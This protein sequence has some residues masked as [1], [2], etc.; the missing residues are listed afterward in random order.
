MG[1]ECVLETVDI[2]TNLAYTNTNDGVYGGGDTGDDGREME[3]GIA[4]R[5]QEGISAL[6]QSSRNSVTGEGDSDEDVDKINGDNS[7]PA[8]SDSQEYYK[9]QYGH[10]E[11]KKGKSGSTSKAKRAGE[12]AEGAEIHRFE[13]THGS[14]FTVKSSKFQGFCTRVEN[15]GK[16]EIEWL[17]MGVS[18]VGVDMGM[19]MGMSMGTD[20]GPRHG[21]LDLGSWIW[22]LGFGVCMWV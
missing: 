1:V 5:G 3:S 8:M 21:V 18:N 6:K 19:S 15:E 10:A 22:G 20:M 11:G 9:Y 14:S 13:V 4:E 12:Y 17:I 7:S 16:N 2:V